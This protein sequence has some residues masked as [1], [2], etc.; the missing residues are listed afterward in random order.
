[1]GAG[2]GMDYGQSEAIT[3]AAFGAKGYTLGVFNDGKT[4]KG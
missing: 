3:L 4:G 2:Y 1:M